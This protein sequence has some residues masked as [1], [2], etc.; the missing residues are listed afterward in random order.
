MSGARVR[1]VLC[2]V[3]VEGVERGGKHCCCEESKK[4]AAGYKRRMTLGERCERPKRLDFQHVSYTV[5]SEKFRVNIIPNSCISIPAI[6]FETM[7]FRQA[8]M[9]KPNG[10]AVPLSLIESLL[11]FHRACYPDACLS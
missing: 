8:R 4:A 1:Y 9:E 3:L 5:V 10:K 6:T 11:L 2:R 7:I